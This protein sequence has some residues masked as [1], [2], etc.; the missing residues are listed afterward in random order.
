[1]RARVVRGE[2]SLPRGLAILD[3]LSY[4]DFLSLQARSAVV[5]T[6]S[7]GI[8]EETTVL[9]IPCRT[10]RENTERPVTIDFGTNRLAGT[11]RETILAAW[12]EHLA[13]PKKG[14]IPPFW[15]GQAALRSQGALRHYFANGKRSSRDA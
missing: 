10:I 13:A 15:D 5:L 2:I 12:R 1:M 11:R 7:G 9:G 3:P 4:L 14:R 8:Q 6:D